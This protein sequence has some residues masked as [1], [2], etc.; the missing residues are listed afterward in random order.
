MVQA[1]IEVLAP[2]E[3]QQVLQ[4]LV[5]PFVPAK[6]KEDVEGLHNNHQDQALA[7]VGLAAGKNS[8]DQ[9]AAVVFLL[10]AEVVPSVVVLVLQLVRWDLVLVPFV[11]QALPLLLLL[12]SSSELLLLRCSLTDLH[13]LLPV[14]GSG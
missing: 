5:V 6:E 7:P 8:L 9:L 14:A 10:L 12:R 11:L 2:I 4:V 1:A 3:V 13:L